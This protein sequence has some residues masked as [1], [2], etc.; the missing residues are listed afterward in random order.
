MKDKKFVKTNRSNNVISGV[1]GGI[2]RG[3]GINVTLLRCVSVFLLFSLFFITILAY[4]VLALWMP[5][6]DD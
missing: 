1:I 2:S 3:T 6:E 5:N 4:I